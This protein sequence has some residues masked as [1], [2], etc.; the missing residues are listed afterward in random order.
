MSSIPEHAKI[1][2]ETLAEEY[3]LL[4]LPPLAVTPGGHLLLSTRP[5]SK[6]SIAA[7]A[8][9][10]IGLQPLPGPWLGPCLV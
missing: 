10:P 5:H 4:R 8:K 2:R 6:Y 1:G 9:W 3:A 7:L